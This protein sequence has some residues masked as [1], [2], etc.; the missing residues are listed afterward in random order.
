[1]EIN[2]FCNYICRDLRKFSNLQKV[3]YITFLTITII[4]LNVLIILILNYNV[5]IKKS[6][7]FFLLL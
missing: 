7:E 2:L 6:Y 1:M 5:R 4:S 3:F